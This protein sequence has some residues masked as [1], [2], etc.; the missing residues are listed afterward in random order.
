M[1]L[2]EDIFMNNLKA[3][4]I[5]LPYNE[6]AMVGKNM[7]RRNVELTEIGLS[8]NLLDH[9]DDDL[10]VNNRQLTKISLDYN[11]LTSISVNLFRNNFEL[12]EINLSHNFLVHLD[13]INLLFIKNLFIKKKLNKY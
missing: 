2:D 1:N 7:F 12:D 11:L 6:L 3:L 13:E 5:I 4:K 8:H 10:F 9:L